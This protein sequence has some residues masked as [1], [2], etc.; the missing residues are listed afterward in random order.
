[1][2]AKGP[3]FKYGDNIDTDVAG[4]AGGGGNN[5]A[6]IN[7]RFGVAAQDALFVPS[8]PLCAART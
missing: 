6:G 1:M 7:K 4:A 2:N 3:V 8:T 5:A